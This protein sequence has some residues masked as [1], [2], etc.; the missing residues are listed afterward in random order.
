MVVEEEDDKVEDDKDKDEED[1]EIEA[2]EV[3]KLE[4]NAAAAEAIRETFPALVDLPGT[5]L[6]KK[7]QSGL[8]ASRTSLL[9]QEEEEEEEEGGEE[10]QEQESFPAAVAAATSSPR[11]RSAA[12]PSSSWISSSVTEPR[13]ASAEA[14]SERTEDVAAMVG[15]R[16]GWREEF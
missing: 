3:F 1:D 6:V 11:A 16:V 5:A 4:S 2:L 9:A 14:H 10:E 12:A 13:K 8:R 7:V 15:G